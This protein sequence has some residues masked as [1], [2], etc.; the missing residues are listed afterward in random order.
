V[1]AQVVDNV[2]RHVGEVLSELIEG[3]TDVRLAVAFVSMSGLKIIED[4]VVSTL[5]AG[6]EIEFLVGMDTKATEAAALRHLLQISQAEPRV[7][8]YCLGSLEGS[9]IYHPK[10]YLSRAE[11]AAQCLV[12][13]SNLTRGGLA[14]NIEV[15]IA[16]SGTL[17]DE[18]IADLYTAYSALKFHPKRVV[19]DEELV[20]LFEDASKAAKRAD[21][22]AKRET[23]AARTEFN[24]KVESLVRPVV[25][26]K[27]LVGWLE[28]VYSVL[29]QD[30]FTNADVYKH[31]ASLRARFPANQSIRA[32]IRQQLQVLRDMGLLSHVASGRW[33]RIG[34]PRA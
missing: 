9:S 8:L 22:V 5:R 18:P 26:R 19:P 6:A 23:R 29:P 28:A 3:G 24:K 14:T 30:E 16:L 11:D 4:A 17:T 33:N 12:G 27:D 34:T 10:V 7:S 21:A 31:E 13:S 1:E 15:N 2:R 32:K 20:A 25:A